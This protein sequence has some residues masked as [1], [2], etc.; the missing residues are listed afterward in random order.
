[1]KPFREKEMR[2]E[3]LQPHIH[4][5]LQY[6][7]QLKTSNLNIAMEWEWECDALKTIFC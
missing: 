7:V 3:T 5:L 2:E 1:M 6:F 4:N